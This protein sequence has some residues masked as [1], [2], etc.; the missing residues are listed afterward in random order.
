MAINIMVF[1]KFRITSNEHNILV[2]RKSIVDPTKA[3]NWPEAKAKGAS[4][5]KRVEWTNTRYYGTVE[6][7][8]MSIAEERIKDSDA[9]TIDELLHEIKGIRR[10]ISDVLSVRV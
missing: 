1:N 6:Q 2:H 7:A 10:E 4:P 3:P 9:T 8:L 5:D